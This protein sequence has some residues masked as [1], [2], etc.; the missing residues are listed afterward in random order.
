MNALTRWLL[1]R[2]CRLHPEG[3][4]WWGLDAPTCVKCKAVAS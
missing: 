2:L 3:H 1:E 4:D